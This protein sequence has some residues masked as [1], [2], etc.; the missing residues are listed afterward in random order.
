MK[1]KSAP[2]AGGM[3]RPTD[4]MATLRAQIPSE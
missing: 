1:T 2:K 4:R 3:D